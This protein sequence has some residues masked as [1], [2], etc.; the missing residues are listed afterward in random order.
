VGRLLRHAEDVSRLEGEPHVPG[1][2]VSG[3]AG[4]Q[5]RS[6]SC[7]PMIGA[8]SFLCD[9]LVKY[10]VAS[11]LVIVNLGENGHV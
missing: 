2:L 10:G 8:A 4:L 11:A 1:Q 3:I 9:E 5:S 7:N 6:T